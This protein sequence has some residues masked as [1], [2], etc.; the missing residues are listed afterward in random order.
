MAAVCNSWH[1]SWGLQEFPFSNKQLA[2]T[3]EEDVIAQAVA[4]PRTP[5]LSE[6]KKVRAPV[7]AISTGSLRTRV[8]TAPLYGRPSAVEAQAVFFK[9]ATSLPKLVAPEAPELLRAKSLPS[10]GCSPLVKRAGTFGAAGDAASPS[11]EQ[12]E[13]LIDSVGV[14]I[15]ASRLDMPSARTLSLEV[16][17]TDTRHGVATVATMWDNDPAAEALGELF[18]TKIL[19]AGFALKLEAGVAGKSIVKSSKKSKK[20][21]DASASGKTGKSKSPWREKSP[22]V[23][24]HPRRSSRGRRPASTSCVLAQ[25]APMP[26]AVEEDAKLPPQARPSSASPSNKEIARVADADLW[27]VGFNDNSNAV[28]APCFWDAGKE[29]YNA[30]GGDDDEWTDLTASNDV[31]WGDDGHTLGE[32]VPLF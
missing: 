18:A 2:S 3:L 10:F 13:D 27:N 16:G 14:A 6:M 22:S 31:D 17:P 25:R 4:L 32:L 1:T 26:L 15:P 9:T 23:H 7:R 5:T 30:W 19:E 20:A 21:K 8:G 29:V 28:Y 11:I 24:N 12:I